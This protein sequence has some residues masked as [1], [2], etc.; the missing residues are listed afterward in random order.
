MGSRC[1]RNVEGTI[2]VTIEPFFEFLSGNEICV[3]TVRS[4]CVK[5]QSYAHVREMNFQS[6]FCGDQQPHNAHQIQTSSSCHP[7]WS[8]SFEHD[9]LYPF[10]LHRCH[11]VL[12]QN[13]PIVPL[14]VE[15]RMLRNEQCATVQGKNMNAGQTL[16]LHRFGQMLVEIMELI[17]VSTRHQ[18]NSVGTIE[19]MPNNVS[20]NLVRT[21]QHELS[22]ISIEWHNSLT[23][24]FT[25]SE[26]K[27]KIIRAY[28]EC[29]AHQK[30]YSSAF[31][32]LK[33][34]LCINSK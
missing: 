23:F 27:R 17:T 13:G 1:G 6:P 15:R 16:K 32:I 11:S 33:R 18:D 9:R 2:A 4:M 14:L 8:M 20:Q 30:N 34:I 21:K 24:T 28:T 22:V 12:N 25:H 3:S 29:P 7:T 5:E 19:P 26:P 31:S 10:Q